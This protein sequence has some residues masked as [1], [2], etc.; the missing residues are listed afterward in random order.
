MIFFRKALVIL[1]V[2]AAMYVGYLSVDF[3][4]KKIKVHRNMGGF[5]LLLTLSFTVIF[6]LIFLLGFIFGEYRN[7]FFKH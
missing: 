2:A 1:I 3:L 5:L 4:K 6:I 7:F